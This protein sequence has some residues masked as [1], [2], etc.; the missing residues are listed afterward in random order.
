[1]ESKNWER[2]EKKNYISVTMEA[3]VGTVGRVS[4]RL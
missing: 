3:K 4:G 2:T 1:M